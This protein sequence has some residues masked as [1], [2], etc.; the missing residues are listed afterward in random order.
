MWGKEGVTGAL[1]G[2]FSVLVG[3]YTDAGDTSSD[4]S[5]LLVARVDDVVVACRQSAVGGRVA[6]LAWLGEDEI[7]GAEVGA[8]QVG[9]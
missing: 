4:A 2:T 9:V 1:G 7:G 3:G 8:G 6:G 5:P